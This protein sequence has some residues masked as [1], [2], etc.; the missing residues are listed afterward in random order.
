MPCT[1]RLLFFTSLQHLLDSSQVYNLIYNIDFGSIPEYSVSRLRRG[2]SSIRSSLWTVSHQIKSCP[3]HCLINILKVLPFSV[4]ATEIYLILDHSGS[5]TI[6]YCPLR[7]EA[8]QYSGFARRIDYRSQLLVFWD[9]TDYLQRMKYFTKSSFC[10]CSKN[11]YLAV[12][13]LIIFKTTLSACALSLGHDNIS[14]HLPAFSCLL[15]LFAFGYN[16]CILGLW[17]VFREPLNFWWCLSFCFSF[18]VMDSHFLGQWLQGSLHLKIFN[19][20]FLW[21][22]WRHL[23]APD[24]CRSVLT[25]CYHPP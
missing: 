12:S 15:Q 5:W 23:C 8:I 13:L 4:H 14:L 2:V 17:L 20:S 25:D 1:F 11:I 6:Y 16:W 24:L 18:A 7:G 10:E 19:H 22:K 21:P 9:C 3:G